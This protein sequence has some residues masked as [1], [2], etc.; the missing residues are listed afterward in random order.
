MTWKASL[1]HR[2]HIIAL[3]ACSRGA[4]PS[5]QLPT[6][7]ARLYILLDRA[8]QTPRWLLRTG[9]SEIFGWNKISDRRFV[10]ESALYHDGM[11]KRLSAA[12]L[13]LLRIVPRRGTKRSPGAAVL[14]LRARLPLVIPTGKLLR[15]SEDIDYA[16]NRHTT[17]T[18]CS[19]LRN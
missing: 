13:R 14:K 7:I 9:S 15:P 10:I 11:L 2:N 17:T 12:F 6:A 1:T 3:E 8:P 18:R 16:V 19:P 5:K 4:C